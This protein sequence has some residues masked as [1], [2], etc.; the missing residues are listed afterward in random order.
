[1]L[2]GSMSV[3]PSVAPRPIVV[4]KSSFFTPLWGHRP[5]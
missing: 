5:I 1:L 2:L 4:W 3:R